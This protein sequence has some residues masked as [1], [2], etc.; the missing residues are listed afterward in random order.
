VPI[1]LQLGEGLSRIIEFL[2][3]RQMRDIAGMNHEGGLDRHGLGL[4][5]CLF[6]RRQR[7]GIGR[8]VKADMA[9]GNLQETEPRVLRTRAAEQ[10][11]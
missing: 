9:V 11:R 3:V 10:S 2:R 8:P 7:I 6:E 4:R 1:G 5:D